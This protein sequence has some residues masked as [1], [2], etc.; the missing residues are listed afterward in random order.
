MG[1]ERKARDEDK[2]KVLRLSSCNHEMPFAKI[3]CRRRRSAPA[4]DHRCQS[5]IAL[6]TK[7][8]YQVTRKNLASIKCRHLDRYNESEGLWVKSLKFSQQ[9]VFNHLIKDNFR[10][11][12]FL[13]PITFLSPKLINKI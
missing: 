9:K 3:E 8:A 7:G 6:S 11:L 5:L 2:E 13:F 1:I 12:N 10:V 4:I